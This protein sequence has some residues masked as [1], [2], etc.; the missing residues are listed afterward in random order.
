MASAYLGYVLYGQITGGLA[1][2]RDFG[3]GKPKGPLCGVFE[4]VG[5]TR[6]DVELAKGDPRRWERVTFNA[7][8]YCS[9]RT[10]DGG[11]RGWRYEAAPSGATVKLT[12]GTGATVAELETVWNDPEHLDLAGE[13]DG[14][15]V[16]VQMQKK[17]FLLESRGFHWINEQP[18]NR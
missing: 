12:P 13:L 2:Y 15:L 6:D 10:G 8:G 4:V 16:V 1:G 11:Q 3:D 7:Y 9:A 5:F 18:F 14:A 17:S